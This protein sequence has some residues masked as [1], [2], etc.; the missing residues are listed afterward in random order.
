MATANNFVI[1]TGLTV[2]TTP[3]INTAGY[4]IGQT[5]GSVGPTGPAGPTG[6]SSATG[7]PPGLS[8]GLTFDLRT[9]NGIINH[10]SSA[11]TLV[12]LSGSGGVD[13]TWAAGAYSQQVYYYNTFTYSDGIEI[14]FG[15][16]QT[17]ADIIV[18]VT[19]TTTAGEGVGSNG[20]T[21]YIYGLY[22]KADG[23]IW[24][25]HYGSIYQTNAS[26][27]TTS[28]YQ[29]YYDRDRVYYFKDGY[30]FARAYSLPT[31]PFRFGASIKNNNAIIKNIN[32]KPGGNR[33]GAGSASYGP[34]GNSG[35]PGPPGPPG[36]SGGG[37]G[38]S[39]PSGPSEP[40]LA[41][42]DYIE[43]YDGYN[44]LITA[45]WITTNSYVGGTYNT[46]EIYLN[47]D[48]SRG[49]NGWQTNSPTLKVYNSTNNSAPSGAAQVTTSN[50]SFNQTPSYGS[51]YVNFYF[52]S[53]PF[54]GTFTHIT[55]YPY[56]IST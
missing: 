4:W 32:F 1:Q 33:G 7:G 39:G 52:Y 17:N 34:P 48:Y 20:Y 49:F 38:P 12:K 54:N 5:A 6:P 24:N 45:G 8:Y 51:S 55:T 35:P 50:F 40:H 13:G 44:Q 16:G 23:S 36:P 26:Q 53:T 11:N 9:K 10:N 27:S 3:V 29:I 43:F 41:L 18:G 19:G 22:F 47:V 30:F 15:V 14:N 56:T 21:D 37:G 46:T 42:G 25:I 2:G 28:I 31:T